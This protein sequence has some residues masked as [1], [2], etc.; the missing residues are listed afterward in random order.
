MFKL[1][2]SYNLPQHI[3]LEPV[4]KLMRGN[5]AASFEHGVFKIELL[6]YF[7]RTIKIELVH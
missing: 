7:T 3:A 2:L 4:P 6:T 1:R 5:F